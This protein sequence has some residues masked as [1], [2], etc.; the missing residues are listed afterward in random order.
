MPSVEFILAAWP[1]D[2]DSQQCEADT[3]ILLNE[4]W[5]AFH[6]RNKA[7]KRLAPGGSSIATKAKKLLPR[8]GH[9]GKDELGG[10]RRGGTGGSGNG[11]GGGLLACTTRPPGGGQ[12]QGIPRG[13]TGSSSSLPAEKELEVFLDLHSRLEALEAGG[14]HELGRRNDSESRERRSRSRSG[15]RSSRSLGVVYK[16]LLLFIMY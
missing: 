14:L 1:A 2:F 6:P 16:K 11:G 9:D 7:N 3:Q 4:M 12:Q 5:K 10:N 13:R 15:S 8:S